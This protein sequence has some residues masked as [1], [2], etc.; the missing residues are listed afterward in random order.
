MGI[1]RIKTSLILLLCLML[2]VYFAVVS[3]A[4]AEDKLRIGTANVTGVYF[5]T[6]GAICR[7]FN[8]G[9]KEHG[10]KCSV[11]PTGG[12]IDNLRAL[13]AGKIEMGI[14]QSDWQFQAYHGKGSFAPK[15]KDSDLRAV[16]S[17]YS[18]P[19]TVV[20]RADSGIR[21]FTDL[22]GKRVDFGNRGSGMRATME[23][24][25]KAYGWKWDDFA[26]VSALKVAEQSDAL[27]SSRV[28]AIIFMAG[29][30]NGAIHEVTSQCATK[31]VPVEGAALEKLLASNPYYSHA[32][33][34]AGMYQGTD[35]TI[36]TFGV[37][38]TLV[39]SKQVDEDT[40]YRLVKAVF[41]RFDD[42]KTLHPVFAG[43]HKEEMAGTANAAPLHKGAERYFQ[44][45]GLI[46]APDESSAI[47]PQTK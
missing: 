38:A 40:V 11:L 41:S 33:I 22:K 42:F 26:K 20:T 44:E 9:M 45:K 39:T 47:L 25:M 6:G 37:K 27:C 12:S 16:F 19:F 18:E 43:L 46:H 13:E 2:G 15:G 8:T 36:K 5:P 34:P 17:L 1:Y 10:I 3:R 24:V 35:E 31:L 28:D 23:M 21:Q 29:S 32:I 4:G 7:L 14:V 30:P